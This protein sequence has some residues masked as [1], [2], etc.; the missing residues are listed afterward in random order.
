MGMNCQGKEA[1][2]PNKTAHLIDWQRVNTLNLNLMLTINYP[3]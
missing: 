3:A 1:N 2:F